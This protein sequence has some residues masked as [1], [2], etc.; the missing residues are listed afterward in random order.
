M[1]IIEI[2]SLTGHSPYDITICDITKSYCYVVASGITSAPITVEIPTELSGTQELIVVITDSSGCETFSNYNCFSPTPTPTFTPTPTITPTNISCNCITF[3]NT[4]TTLGAFSYIDCDNQEINFKINS[5]TTLYVC[6]KS[7]SIIVGDVTYSMGLP[8]VNNTCV[9]PTPTPTVTPSSTPVIVDCVSYVTTGTT[10]IFKY[11]VDTNGLTLLTFPSLPSI[12]D[13]ANNSNKFWIT[14]INNP[15]EITEYYI[16]PIP[17]VATYNRVLY[18]SQPLLG[19]CVKNDVTLISTI[20]GVTVGDSYIIVEV[21]I[22]GSVPVITNKFSLPGTGRALGGDIF[23]FPVTDKLFVANNGSGNWYLTQYD[24]TTGTLEYDVQLNPSIVGVFGLSSENNNLYLF[25]VTGNV[26][27]L[28]DITIPT[29]TLVQTTISGVGAASSDVSCAIVPT[30]TPTPTP[31]HT[32]SCVTPVLSSVTQLSGSTYG[33]IFT[34]SYGCTSVDIEY[35]RDTITWTADTGDCSTSRIVDTG[36]G[37]G[38]WYFRV[39]QLCAGNYLTGNTLSYIP[40]T[41]TPTPTITPTQTYPYNNLGY[42]YI[43]P[44]PQDV[45]SLGDLSAYM[46]SSGSTFLGWGNSGLP[47]TVGYSNN[48]DIYIHYSGFTGGSGNFISNVNTLKSSDN[49]DNFGCT[50]IGIFNTIEI[51]ATNVNPN[52]QYFYTIWVPIPVPF[53]PSVSNILVNIG[54]ASPCTSSILDNGVPDSLLVSQNVFVT[55]GSPIPSGY[56]KVLWLDPSCLLPTISPPPALE[57]PLYFN[58]SG[59]V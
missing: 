40:V 59:I 54:Y 23:Y 42:T 16:N 55:S 35:S 25:E 51:T 6:G 28:D 48:L 3:T 22:S 58:G 46:T 50:S 2:T 9:L 15:Q 7:P 13:I 52:I 1:Q 21:D 26:Y 57:F 29:F 14:D 44:E 4:G 39:I 43:V 53:P 33:V 18:P 19:L 20:T 49:S 37:T 38:T 17:F 32:I 30:P 45:T 34:N 47:S 10:D 24:Y 41:P 36:D 56:Y 11:D 8:C 31:T 12:S 5:G 27:R